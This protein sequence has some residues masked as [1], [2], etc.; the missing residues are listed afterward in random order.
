[1]ATFGGFHKHVPTNC[2]VF[3]HVKHRLYSFIMATF[4]GFHKHVPTNCSVFIHDQHFFV[5]HGNFGWDT[6]WCSPQ[7]F[8]FSP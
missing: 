1:M 2:S 4:G 8:V 6:L 7:L 3:I 5:H